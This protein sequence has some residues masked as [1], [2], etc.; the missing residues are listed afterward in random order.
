[1]T[2]IMFHLYNAPL[3][4]CAAAPA[5]DWEVDLHIVESSGVGTTILLGGKQNATDTQDIYDLPLPP[6]PPQF[7]F[8]LA[9][10]QTGFSEPF[11]RLLHEFKS[12]SS[13]VVIWNLSVL[14]FAESENASLITIQINWDIFQTM[15]S[16][17]DSL[18]IYQNNTI[19]ANMYTDDSF[20]FGTNGSLHNFQIIGQRE[21]ADNS[22]IQTEDLLLPLLIVIIIVV[23]IIIALFFIKK[24]RR[25]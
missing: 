2:T 8:L 19:V 15:T 21:P 5:E 12:L 17:Y 10:F 20:T 11:N 24:R 22:S 25:I 6:N 13:D 7:P 3:L 14:W 18:L 23:L 16:Q 9:W 4:L 1:M